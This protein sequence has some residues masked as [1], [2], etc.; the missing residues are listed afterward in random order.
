MMNGLSASEIK[1]V[2]R[3]I[4]SQ[5]VTGEMIDIKSRQEAKKQMRLKYLEFLKESKNMEEVL[6][7]QN[8]INGI[9]EDIEAATIRVKYLSHHDAC[10]TINL[11]FYQPVMDMSHTISILHF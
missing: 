5:D 11:T 2:E 1:L 3:K 6:K 4:V 7:V 9:Q 8:E 10:S